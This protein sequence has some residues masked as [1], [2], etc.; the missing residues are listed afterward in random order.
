[1]HRRVLIGI[2]AVLVSGIIFCSPAMSQASCKSALQDYRVAV[3]TYQDGLFDPAIAG[4]EAYLQQCPDGPYAGQAH[5]ILAT[6]Y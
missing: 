6:I 1:M 5:Y 2:S 4:F 3:Q